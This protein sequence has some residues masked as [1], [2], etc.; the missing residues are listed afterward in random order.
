MCDDEERAVVLLIAIYAVACASSTPAAENRRRRA[1]ACSLRPPRDCRPRSIGKRWK[2]RMREIVAR[3]GKPV[4]A[5]TVDVEAAASI[6]IPDHPTIRGAL[7]YFTTDLKPSI[8]ES[9]LR[10]GKYKKLI[11]KALDDYKLPHG[12]AYLPVI[13]SAYVPSVTSRAGAHGIWQ[14]MPETARDYGLR[15]DW[16]V[17]ERADPERST[18]AAAAYLEGSLSPVQRLAARAGRVQRRSGPHPPRHAVVRRRHVLGPARKRSGP[19]R[20]ARLRPDV[21]R[22]AHD[23]QRSVHVRFPTRHS[24]SIST[25][26]PSRSKVRSPSATSPRSRTSTKR[27]CAISIPRCA[28][29]SCRRDKITVRVPSKSAEAV[30]ARAATLKK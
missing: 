26:A 12:L 4:A 22:H 24:R 2:R 19:E 27:C 7:Q 6:P 11:D 20:D 18:R 17:D 13:E 23:R 29:A 30:A 5:P 3:E 28:R 10:S 21:L 16:W 25:A 15:V 9:L 14:F 1:R 8:Q